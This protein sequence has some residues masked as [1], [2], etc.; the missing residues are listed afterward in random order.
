MYVPC[1]HDNSHILR[2]A[3]CTP[4]THTGLLVWACSYSR[5]CYTTASCSLPITL[6]RSQRFDGGTPRTAISSAPSMCID[7]NGWC[8]RHVSAFYKFTSDAYGP[9]SLCVWSCLQCCQRSCGGTPSAIAST[10]P[11]SECIVD[12]Q[13]GPSA[14]LRA[15]ASIVSAH[16]RRNVS[17]T[18]FCDAC[19][20]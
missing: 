3:Q 8:T 13:R 20:V 18:R 12:V 19:C 16:K 17:R 1:V 9:M 5:F 10:A 2:T 14:L 4:L 7:D 6:Q 11:T 15:C